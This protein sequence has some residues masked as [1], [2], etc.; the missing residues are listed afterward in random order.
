M[1]QASHLPENRQ[2]TTGQPFLLAAAQALEWQLL[3][4]RR[5]FFPSWFGDVPFSLDRSASGSRAQQCSATS[6]QQLS[7]FSVQREEEEGRRGKM[8][9][10]EQC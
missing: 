1:V 8:R 6:P 3:L 9:E 4:A 2:D 7:S 10:M 5:G